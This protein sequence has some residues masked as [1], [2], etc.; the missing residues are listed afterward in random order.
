[1]PSFSGAADGLAAPTNDFSIYSKNS[2]IS[3]GDAKYFK[4]T[5]NFYHKH[6][7]SRRIVKKYEKYNSTRLV[8]K[9]VENTKL[10][11]SCMT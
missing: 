3:N 10:A 4:T 7:L 11:L 9:S 5:C 8:L 1:M 6:E 2:F